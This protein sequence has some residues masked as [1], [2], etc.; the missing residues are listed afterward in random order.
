MP[1]VAIN[2]ADLLKGPALE[3]GQ[4]SGA[5]AASAVVV[6]EVVGAV[7]ADE[8]AAG[9]DGDVSIRVLNAAEAET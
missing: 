9:G 7:A 5:E 2:L 4:A 8:E 3:G 6:V 1:S